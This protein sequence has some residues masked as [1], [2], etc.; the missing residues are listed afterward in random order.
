MRALDRMMSVAIVA[1]LVLQPTAAIGGKRVLIDAQ[2]VSPQSVTVEDVTYRGIRALRVRAVIDQS[3]P[4]NDATYALLPVPTSSDFTI[5]ADVAG[6]PIDTGSVARGFVGLAF[7]VA[8]DGKSFEAIYLRPS[9][10]RAEDQLRRNRSVQYISHP[11]YPWHRLREESPGLYESYTDLVPGRWTHM[12]IEVRG[13]Q[14]KL[15]VDRAEQPC[16]IVN[17]LKRGISSGRFG[18]W[19]GPGS[20]AHFSNVT[21]TAR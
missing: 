2:A 7:R 16:L 12:K 15:F 4:D 19:V 13:K 18:L 1:T 10:G 3:N 5:E 20:I 8:D 6:E 14:A 11:D 17:D 21:V 9:N